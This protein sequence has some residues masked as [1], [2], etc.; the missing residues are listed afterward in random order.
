MFVHNPLFHNQVVNDAI[1]HAKN[2]F[3]KE[4]VGIVINDK[5][6]S[7][8]N[9]S[10]D[11]ENTWLIEDKDFY[12]QSILGNIQAIIHSHNNFAHAS[13]IDQEKQQEFDI[14]FGIVNVINQELITHVMFWGKGIR[15]AGPVGRAFF[16]GVHDCLTLVRDY[17]EY[18]DIDLPNPPRDLNFNEKGEKLFEQYLHTVPFIQIG[19]DDLQKDDLLFYV[20]NGQIGHVGV[21]MGG[22]TILSHWQNQLSGYH[23]ISYKRKHLSFAMRMNQ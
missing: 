12:R 18:Y 3:P 2:Q 6:K 13:A 19:L 20:W 8:R 14:P 15:M 7:L 10:E 1:E 23:D 4:S 9:D 22:D 5:Y 16:F 17:Y 21:Y 11:P